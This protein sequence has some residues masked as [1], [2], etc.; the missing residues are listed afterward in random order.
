MEY[1]QESGLD[2]PFG[3]TDDLITEIYNN[4]KRASRHQHDWRR[5]ARSE[6]EFRD[7]HQ[8]DNDDKAKLEEQGRPV[9]TFNRVT[10]IID[11]IVGNEINNRQEIRFVP[12]TQGDGPANE[13]YTA[14]AKWIR[15]EC[16][17]EDEESDSFNDAV[18][19]G[20][21]WTETYIDYTEHADGK[22]IIERVPALQMRW[23]PMSR[24]RNLT[25]AN[26]FQREKIMYLD[27]IKKRWPGVELNPMP[28]PDDDDEWGEEHDS[29]EAWKYEQDWS[30]DQ[31]LIGDD[32]KATVIHYQW[33]EKE[34]YFR[35]ADPQ[36]GRIVEFDP[37]RMEAIRPQ[38]EAMG[39]TVV[40]QQKWVYKKAFVVGKTIL[41]SG[42]NAVQDFT[43]KVM[44]AK[45]DER[46]G[47]WYGL[48]RA[49][50]D[51]Q[52]WANKFF[53]QT[54][55][56]LNSNAKGGLMVERTA[57]D[58][59]DQLQEDWA[60]PDAVVVLED[61]AIAGGRIQEK[62][63]PGYPSGLDK[64]LA[65]A[66]SSIRDVSGVNLE[67]LGMMGK[68]QPGILEQERKRAALTILAPIINSLRHYR[69]SQGRLLLKF[70]HEYIPEGTVVRLT[71]QQ[72]VS[73]MRDRD[74][75]RF[76]IIVDTATTSPNLK[77]EVWASLQNILPQLVG[78]GVPIPPDIVDFS[79]LPES[80]AMKWKEYMEQQSKGDPKMQAEMQKLQEELQKLGEENQLL[81][82]KKE[83]HMM[84][85]QQ[86]RETSILDKEIKEQEMAME[87]RAAQMELVLKKDMSDKDRQTKLIEISAKYD[88]EI[89]KIRECAAN[90]RDKTRTLNQ[91]NREMKVIDMQTKREEIAQKREEVR[92]KAEEKKAVSD[93]QINKSISPFTAKVEMLEKEIETQAEEAEKRRN[94][95]YE[96]LGKTERFKPVIDKLKGVE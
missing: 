69:K 72:D 78:A 45:R 13:T 77:T 30:W 42:E 49:M 86:K 9:V 74:I 41:E 26:W 95:L 15:Q 66:I 21:G 20:M 80:V 50:K 52:R 76:D 92:A 34:E 57:V 27:D 16:D 83:E 53:S 70:I 43:F 3:D 37:E 64:L 18:T 48:M 65:F 55:H 84:T 75:D 31:T 94:I 87:W 36:S 67:L 63:S 12:R 59:L 85:L 91:A 25:D 56:I 17:A 68:E 39:V 58:N 24:K 2:N 71:D 73:F 1:E 60:S 81:K 28:T 61:G 40:R 38:L 5:D 90:E 7:G 47:V 19:I 14:V 4:R 32:D 35:V 82:A 33:R 29:T 51:P 79:P 89:Q 11:S 46:Y 8:W 44:T 93:E 88:L 22:V 62:A 23:D 10:P 54:M 6:Y 96:F